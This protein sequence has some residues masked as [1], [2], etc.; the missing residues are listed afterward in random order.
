MYYLIIYIIRDDGY[1][2]GPFNDYVQCE[3][4][5]KIGFSSDTKYKITN[6]ISIRYEIYPPLLKD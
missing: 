3:S 2:I 4:Y 1:A 6:E 5:L